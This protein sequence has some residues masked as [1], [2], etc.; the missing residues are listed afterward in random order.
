LERYL[1]GKYHRT[2][3]KTWR[4]ESGLK[5]VYRY[6]RAEVQIQILRESVGLSASIEW[7]NAPSAN[8][9]A[10]VLYSS[11]KEKRT[12]PHERKSIRCMSKKS[13]K[14]AQVVF[15]EKR[16]EGKRARPKTGRRR[17]PSIT[18]RYYNQNGFVYCEF[19]SRVIDRDGDDEQ[20]ATM[21][22]SERQTTETG[23]R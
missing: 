23:S 7:T 10:T 3:A 12:R 15:D 6:I 2:P 17:T 9:L 22:S 8:S 11:H 20:R 4:V 14:E 5:V 16:Q 18:S 19:G 21:Q 13:W 1:L